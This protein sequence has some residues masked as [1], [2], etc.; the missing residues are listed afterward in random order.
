[1]LGRIDL[2]VFN[3]VNHMLANPFIDGIVPYVTELASGETLFALGAALAI[4]SK[5]DNRICG[6]L[7]LAG[8]TISYHT[9]EFIKN[10]AA[11]SR[12]FVA[13]PDARVLVSHSFGYSFP[14]GHTASAFMAAYIIARQYGRSLVAVYLI[15]ALVAFS[16]VYAGVHYMSDVAGGA[17]IGS[18]IGYAL[19]KLAGKSR[20]IYI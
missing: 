2:S 4:F 20:T 13:I 15:A 11:V 3:F 18:L 6:I 12:P 1:M 14:S 8:L 17:V 19:V 7:I 10:T 9:V 16:R 5:K